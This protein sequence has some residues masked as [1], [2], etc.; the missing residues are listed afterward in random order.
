[1]ARFVG[2]LK[3]IGQVS[4]SLGNFGKNSGPAKEAYGQ[5]CNPESKGVAGRQLAWRSRGRK[6][7]GASDRSRSAFADGTNVMTV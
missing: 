5:C 4:G 7:E 2:H 6:P 1:M 3:L